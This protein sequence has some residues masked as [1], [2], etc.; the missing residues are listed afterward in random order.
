[1]CA[2]TKWYLGIDQAY[3][4]RDRQFAQVSN[5]YEPHFFKLTNHHGTVLLRSVANVFRIREKYLQQ[6]QREDDDSTTT[7][8]QLAF[9]VA[10]DHFAHT[11]EEL[12]FEFFSATNTEDSVDNDGRGQAQDGVHKVI[13]WKKME[14]AFVCFKTGGFLVAAESD[15]SKAAVFHLLPR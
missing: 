6:Y 12:Q 9:D 4:Y 1:M 3:C 10:A 5:A 2:Q 8:S 11:G 7:F 13:I 14:Q 15:P